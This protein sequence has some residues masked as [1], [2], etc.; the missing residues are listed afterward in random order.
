MIWN[1]WLIF[2]LVVGLFCLSTYFKPIEGER[3]PRI[4]TVG[5]LSLAVAAT[6]LPVTYAL[7]FARLP[8]SVILLRV[9]RGILGGMFGTTTVSLGFRH[10][11][12]IMLIAAAI[13]FVVSP[14]A[15]VLF[16]TRRS[17][18]AGAALY[19]V[20]TSPQ[21]FSLEACPVG[22]TIPVLIFPWRPSS[23]SREVTGDDKESATAEQDHED[24]TEA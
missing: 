2:H 9:T 17:M 8:H 16:L 19:A 18:S 22:L 20:F 23:G 13:L 5:L 15:L 11:A 24:G 21:I 10:W 6:L 12:K 7:L 4:L 1:I 14:L 3:N